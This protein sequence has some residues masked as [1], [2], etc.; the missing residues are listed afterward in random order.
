MPGAEGFLGVC[1]GRLI[2]ANSPAS[3]GERPSNWEAVL[4]HEFCHVVTLHKT[5]NKMPRW[6]SEGISVYEE[7]VRNPGWG[8]SINAQYRQMIVDGEMAPVSQLSSAFLTP[9][10][11]LHLQ[12]AYFQSAMVVEFLVERF[13]LEAVKQILADLGEGMEINESLI[14]RT[15]PLGQLDRE[16]EEFAEK[17]V[18][19]MAPNATWEEVDLPAAANAGAL[20]VWL[21]DYPNNVPAL[22]R[23]AAGLIREEK[24]RE[25][26]DVA[27]RLQELFPGDIGGG[28]AH[29]I[30]AAAYRAL[31]ENAEERQALEW[32]A[33]HDGDAID[34]SLRLIELGEAAGDWKSVE[35]NARRML[36]VNPL[37]VAP[38]RAMA[39]A[40][41]KLENRGEAIR[42]YR[43]LLKFDTTDPADNHFRL[44][45]LLFA[46]GQ[47]D[48]AKR[49]VLMSLDEAP[50]YQDA[51]RL[52]LELASADE[53]KN[54]DAQDEA[55]TKESSR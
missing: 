38:H 4:W 23:L 34:S 8:Q 6:L 10:T 50:R 46:E 53:N 28:N 52:L 40:S 24:Y 20:A 3:Q 32:I 9:K 19:E 16:F 18:A 43:A 41:E 14:R 7:R 45:A 48:E 37:I 11:P 30:M 13:G 31:G 35:V 22:Q 21:E 25:A 47:N 5:K 26:L 17:R 33:E 54:A 42:S 39:K 55:V 49:Q 12:F 27:K 36:A 51:H 2:T 15:I 44:A 1:F 29:A